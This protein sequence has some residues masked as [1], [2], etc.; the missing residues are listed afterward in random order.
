M[1]RLEVSIRRKVY[2]DAPTAALEE[3]NFRAERGELVAVVGPS[4]SGKST[5][6]NIIGGLDRDLEGSVRIDEQDITEGGTSGRVGF[7]FQAPR[8]MPWLSALDNVRLVLG[9]QADRTAR[10]RRLLGEVELHGF[11]QAFPGQLSG[12]MQRR[13][14]LARA[15][16]V[17]PALLLMDEPFV[18]LDAPTAGRLR[19]Q[20]LA[21]WQQLKPTVLYVTHDLREALAIADRVLFLSGRPGRVVLD[22]RITLSRPRDLNDAGVSELHARLLREHP[23]ILSGLAASTDHIASAAGGPRLAYRQ[24]TG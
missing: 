15:F 14:A 2:P 4:G 7:I 5:L 11:E 19:Q 13:V 1:S 9:E 16:A 17:E 8:L 6:L 3:L 12:G 24:H 10:A 23:D 22:E 20:L 21:L 18:S